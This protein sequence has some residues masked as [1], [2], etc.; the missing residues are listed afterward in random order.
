MDR[1]FFTAAVPMRLISLGHREH[2]TIELAL[3]WLK[4][5]WTAWELDTGTWYNLWALLCLNPVTI[6]LST[7]QYQRCYVTALDWLPHLGPQPLTWLLD[8]LQ[9]AGYS[10]KEPLVETG[11]VQLL[12]LQGDDGLWS[13]P[14]TT[15]ETTITALRL[16]HDYGKLDPRR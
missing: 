11:I 1:F 13:D 16:L 4:Q 6:G 3:R 14:H 15:V 5:H 10:A 8:A 9:G 12:A 2:S 7:S